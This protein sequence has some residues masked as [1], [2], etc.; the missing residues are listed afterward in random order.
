[1]RCSDYRNALSLK[2]FLYVTAEDQIFSLIFD[3]SIGLYI[4]LPGTSI[5]GL[6]WNAFPL[7]F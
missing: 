1:M 4:A 6:D 5:P 2:L 3:E 7:P